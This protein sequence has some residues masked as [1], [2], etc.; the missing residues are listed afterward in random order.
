MAWVG[1]CICQDGLAERKQHVELMHRLYSKADKMIALLG[2][3]GDGI[4]D[5][6]DLLHRVER[7]TACFAEIIQLPSKNFRGPWNQN[8]CLKWGLPPIK[9]PS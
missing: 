4:K 8:D 9:D 7:A 2:D 5:I 1:L 6:T 3:Q